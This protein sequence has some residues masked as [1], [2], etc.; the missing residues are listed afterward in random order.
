MG[1]AVFYTIAF[2]T[3]AESQARWRKLILLFNGMNLLGLFGFDFL[4]GY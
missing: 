4:I 1:T 2:I 3:K